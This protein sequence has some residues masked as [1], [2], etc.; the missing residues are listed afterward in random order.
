MKEKGWRLVKTRGREEGGAGL[1]LLMISEDQEGVT[2]IWEEELM[3]AGHAP[4]SHAAMCL[5]LDVW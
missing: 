2:L 4:C 5:Q 3:V 1:G